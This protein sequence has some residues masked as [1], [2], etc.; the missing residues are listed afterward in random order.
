MQGLKVTGAHSDL[1][2]VQTWIDRLADEAQWLRFSDPALCQEWS[3]S[4]LAL[5]AQDPDK[6]HALSTQIIPELLTS[7]PTIR[8]RE[9]WDLW[10][11]RLLAALPELSNPD[12]AQL[13]WLIDQIRQTDALLHRVREQL[14]SGS[15][16]L[17]QGFKNWQAD[18]A[19]QTVLPDTLRPDTFVI[20]ET[21]ATTPGNVVF[22]NQLFQLIQYQPQ[23]ETTH[24]HPIL[25]IPAF[26]NRYY[27]LDLTPESSMVQWLVQSGHTVFMMSWVNPTE[28]L[29]AYEMTHYVLDGCVQAM[30]QL[31]RMCPRLPVQVMGYCAG[32][33]LASILTAWMSARGEGDRICSLSLLTT[34]LDYDAPGPLGRFVTEQSIAHVESVMQDTGYLPAA[35]SLRTFASLRPHDLYVGRAINSYVLGQRAKP[36]PLFHWLGDGTRIPAAMVSWILRTLY[37]ENGLVCGAPIQLAGQ[38]IDLGAIQVPTYAM[39][40][41]SDEIAPWRSVFQ[42]VQGIDGPVRRVLGRGGHNGGVINPPANAKYSYWVMSDVDP[43]D[44]SKATAYEGSWWSD[45][46]Q[47]LQGSAGALVSPPLI[48]GGLRPAIEK[49]PGRYVKAQ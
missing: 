15:I 40:A 43:L 17:E 9:E 48:G 4:I 36:M 13:I 23:T 19:A 5:A 3:E 30:D 14:D 35:I 41:L 31:A 10:V 8:S 20:G 44:Q 24:A 1:F 38:A 25:M 39:G 28:S 7:L 6:W 47:F 46:G 16:D 29:R 26:V 21:L 42:G 27:I 37:R 49:A 34:L 22:E 45:W 33:V 12:R 11:A 18:L 2:W 32:G